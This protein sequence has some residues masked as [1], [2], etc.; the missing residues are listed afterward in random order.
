MYRG[1]LSRDIKRQCIKCKGEYVIRTFSFDSGFCPD[2][3]PRFF[4]W[5]QW[6]ERSPAATRSLWLLLVALHIAFLPFFALLL[7]GGVIS[8]PGSLYCIT[9]ILYFAV[10]FGLVRATGWPILTRLQVVALLLL[11]AY[12]LA[13]FVAL[14]Y[15]S[16]RIRYGP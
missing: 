9:A 12:G 7:D 6:S 2:C 3:Q 14:F 11:P 10:Q 4:S 8:I 15:L 1:V 16:Q 5:P 13:V